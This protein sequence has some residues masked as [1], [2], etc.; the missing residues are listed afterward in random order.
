MDKLITNARASCEQAA[1]FKGDPS[2]EPSAHWREVLARFH[3]RAF[4]SCR[5]AQDLVSFATEN[6][7]FVIYRLQDSPH[8]DGIILRY[9]DWLADAGQSLSGLPQSFVESPFASSKVLFDWQGRTI[10]TSFLWHLCA[11]VRLREL[12]PKPEIVMEIG[13]GFGG[14]ARLM[15]MALPETTF[16]LVDLPE[17]LVFTDVYLRLNFPELRIGYISEPTN[18]DLGYLHRFDFLLV[19]NNLIDNLRGLKVDLAINIASFGE[20]TQESTN[21]YLRFIEDELHTDALYSINQYGNFPTD[22]SA[23]RGKR[24][25][26]GN[27]CRV[28]L[29]VNA[30]WH[31]KSW[32]FLEENSFVQADPLMAPCLE[33]FLEKPAGV[34]HGADWLAEMALSQS[35][36][37]KHYLPGSSQWHALLWNSLRL[38][39]TCEGANLLREWGRAHDY[40]EFVQDVASPPVKDG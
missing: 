5:T 38:D 30:Q 40:P 37:A 18:I 13:T 29:P 23:G 28:A 36:Q 26:S 6:N 14:L 17:T 39:D 10:S 19:P 21:S 33:V 31:L 3:Y 16:L 9:L 4:A 15:R 8:A 11:A 25:T 12:C 35:A 2:L 27:V 22:I 32:H 24:L 7:G 20:M 34:Q 1:A